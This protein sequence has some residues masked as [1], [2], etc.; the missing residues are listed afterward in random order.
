MEGVTEEDIRNFEKS[1]IIQRS[2]NMVKE[3]AQQQATLRSNRSHYDKVKS[4][5]ARCINVRNEVL[6]ASANTT[7]KKKQPVEETPAQEFLNEALS[8]EQL[9]MRYIDRNSSWRNKTAL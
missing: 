1:A 2:V 5:V 6:R 7:A 4:K 3:R 8:V 9:G